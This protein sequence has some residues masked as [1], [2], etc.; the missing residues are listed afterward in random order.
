MLF[1]LDTC[2]VS[3]FFRKQGNVV[4]HLKAHRPADIKLSAITVME[5]NYG[6][7]LNPALQEKITPLWHELLSQVEAI[8]FASEEARQAAEVRAYLK[9][10]GTPIGA[11]DLLLGATALSHKLTF[12][13]AN[14]KEFAR[15]PN[16]KIENWI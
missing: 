16:L 13:T 3:Y 12:V 10:Q 9:K 2:T 15:I 14:I 5:V 8:P 11:Y 7:C 6:L 4:E 1:L